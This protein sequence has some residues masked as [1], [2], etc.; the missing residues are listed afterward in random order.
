MYFITTNK[1]VQYT[2]VSVN[3]EEIFNT[4]IDGEHIQYDKNEKFINTYAAFDIYLLKQRLLTNEP[5]L[6]IIV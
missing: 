5:L 3:N 4:L 2:G 6:K 1:E